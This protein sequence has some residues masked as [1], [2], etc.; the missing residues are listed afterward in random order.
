[1]YT[2]EALSKFG[3]KEGRLM[4]WP[5]CSPDLNP[6]ENFW[7]LLK[8]KVYESGKQFSSKNCLWE[9][10]QSSAAAIHKDAIKNLTDSMSNRLIKVI[11]AKGDYIHY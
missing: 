5:A 10:I 9:A 3:F 2:C 7:S 6:I 8:S 11:S 4:M 1:C